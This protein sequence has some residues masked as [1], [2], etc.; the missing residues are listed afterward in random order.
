[1]NTTLAFDGR[2]ASLLLAG[3]AL[4]GSVFRVLEAGKDLGSDAPFDFYGISP[5][6]LLVAGVAVRLLWSRERV[7]VGAFALGGVALT[8]AAMLWPSSL[9]AWLLT[10]ALACLLA[11]GSRGAMRSGALLF[12]ALG[13]W[14]AWSA[15]LEPVVSGSLL[16]L[17]AGAVARFLSILRDDVVRIGNVVGAP[18]GHR[19]VVLVG[20]STAHFLPLPMLGAAALLLVRGERVGLPAVLG[21][22]ALAIALVAMNVTRLTLMAWSADLYHFV[23]GASGATIFDALTSLAILSAALALPTERRLEAR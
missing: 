6:E 23:H 1:M 21:L 10:T 11:L 20:C 7:F 12:A 3:G 5:F 15:V 18:E 17:D 4:N 2:F 22:A 16:A 14:E 8:M 13:A 9:V 19:I